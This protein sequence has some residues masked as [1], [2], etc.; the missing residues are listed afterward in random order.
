MLSNAN[1]KALR[2]LAKN[3]TV[4]ILCDEIKDRIM[5]TISSMGV[6]PDDAE[7]S[8]QKGKA[9]GMIEILN[10]IKNLETMEEKSED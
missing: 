8:F 7:C 9:N 1:I 5:V 2:S 10:L 6:A 4:A 3:P